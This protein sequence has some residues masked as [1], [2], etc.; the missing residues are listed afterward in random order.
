MGVAL[1]PRWKVI[2]DM[3]F[4]T[5]GVVALA[6]IAASSCAQTSMRSPVDTTEDGSFG[7]PDLGPADTSRNQNTRAPFDR[8]KTTPSGGLVP[9]QSPE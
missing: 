2:P 5:F 7:Y 1:S 3:K 4:M 6:A 8:F 9:G